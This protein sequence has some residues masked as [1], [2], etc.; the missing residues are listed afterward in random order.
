MRTGTNPLLVIRQFFNLIT[1]ESQK[2]RELVP[3]L[4][5]NSHKF[6][7][8]KTKRNTLSQ[9]TCSLFGPEWPS[10]H[11]CTSSVSDELV[12]IQ[13]LNLVQSQRLSHTFYFWATPSR[14]FFFT[15]GPCLLTQL[16]CSKNIFPPTLLLY[17][18]YGFFFKPLFLFVVIVN[19]TT[20]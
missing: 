9:I 2:I 15:W 5:A 7:T 3:A 18:C 19:A 4:R 13:L 10:P 6:L 1:F 17:L 16:P 12:V 14:D 11:D 20:L 8:S